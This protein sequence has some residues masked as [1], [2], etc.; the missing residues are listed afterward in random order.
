MEE[1]N[2]TTVPRMMTVRQI[3]ATKILSENAL[4]KMVKNGTAPRIMVGNKALINYDKLV[5]MLE[6]C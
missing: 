4:R 5:Q 2:T 1:I 6:G 3:A